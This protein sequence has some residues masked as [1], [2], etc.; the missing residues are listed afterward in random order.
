MERANFSALGLR[1]CV[2][3]TLAIIISP[4]RVAVNSVLKPKTA[5]IEEKIAEIQRAIGAMQYLSS[6][7]VNGGQ[8]P[9]DSG[10]E[11]RFWADHVSSGTVGPHPSSCSDYDFLRRSFGRRRGS[12]GAVRPAV[13]PGRDLPAE[14]R[15]LGV[16]TPGAG[17]GFICFGYAEGA[18]RT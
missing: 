10:V 12:G 17:C 8:E 11:A 4:V 6:G 13:R 3:C 14:I 2:C 18:R 1:G 9:P 7:T 15:W 16:R 5:Q